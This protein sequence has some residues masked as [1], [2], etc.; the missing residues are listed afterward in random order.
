M[1]SFR[2]AKAQTDVVQS[3]LHAHV[4]AL[5]FPWDSFL[6]ESILKNQMIAIYHENLLIGYANIEGDLLFSFHVLLSHYSHAPAALENL[7]Q[8]YQLRSVLALTS[9]PLLMSLLF[10]W[11]YAV[12]ERLGCFFADQGRLAKPQIKAANPLFRQAV[13]SDIPAIL[14]STEDFF[15]NIADRVRQQTIFLL[16]D[17]AE[18]LGCGIMEKSK[19]FSNCVSIGMVTPKKHRQKG[20][21]QTILWHLK[22]YAY[23]LQL[24][25][26]AGCWYYNV[27][28][29]KSLEAAGLIAAT[30]GLVLTLQGK[31]TLPLRTGNPPGELV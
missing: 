8:A 4:K 6:E 29:R 31:K 10:E 2:F 14:Q 1:L 21:A 12:K 18:L 15:D 9:D 3:V 11:D 30:K 16:E 28:S 24:Q 25:P 20:V 5:S 13:E 22:E 7:I 27:L 17:G 26:I 19:F 23:G